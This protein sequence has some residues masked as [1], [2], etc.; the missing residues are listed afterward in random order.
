[1]SHS[2]HFLKGSGLALGKGI[3]VNRFLE[4]NLPNVYAVGDCAEQTEPLTGRQAVEAVWYTGRIM[5][6]TLAQTLT[7]RK[8]AY[9]PG[10]WFN[11]AKFC[12]NSIFR[13]NLVNFFA[14][15][16]KSLQNQ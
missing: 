13:R 1:M 5:G 6:E 10:P 4:T 16:K 3:Q 15:T 11:S 7:D 12:S 14:L 2:H 9:Q 8:T